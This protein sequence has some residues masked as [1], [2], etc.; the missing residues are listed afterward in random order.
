MNV[1]APACTLEHV[2]MQYMMRHS[3]SGTD[4]FNKL[5]SKDI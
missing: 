5:I 1:D 2:L 4:E 3:F